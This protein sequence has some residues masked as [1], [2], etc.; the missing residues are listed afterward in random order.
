[1]ARRTLRSTSRPSNIGINR[2]SKRIETE[3]AKLGEMQESLRVRK[4]TLKSSLRVDQDTP[5]RHATRGRIDEH[6]NRSHICPGR[7]RTKFESSNNKNRIFGEEPLRRDWLDGREMH[8]QRRLPAGRWKR[9][10][11]RE[12]WKRRRGNSKRPSRKSPQ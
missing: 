12:K 10:E 6:K 2:E 3:S 4:E 1:M 7:A 9:R 8:R 11:F 5:R